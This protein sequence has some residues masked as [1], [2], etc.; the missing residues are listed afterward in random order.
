MCRP[1]ERTLT[2]AQSPHF[3]ETIVGRV[4]WTRSGSCPRNAP[5]RRRGSRKVR[6]QPRDDSRIPGKNSVP[7][8]RNRNSSAS[9]CDR[10]WSTRWRDLRKRLRR[11]RAR[12]RRNAFARVGRGGWSK[13]RF[14]RD[15]H[16]PALQHGRRRT[17][18]DLRCSRRERR[19]AGPEGQNDRSKFRLEQGCASRMINP[20]GSVPLT[21]PVVN[22][23]T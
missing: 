17:A 22:P 9:D 2:V 7:D 18:Y 13:R 23:A 12:R 1:V 4:E 14:D 5:R 3:Y 10:S 16:E 19:A 20:A 11:Q 6:R 8:M 21:D 15:A